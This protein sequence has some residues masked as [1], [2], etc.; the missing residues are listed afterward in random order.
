MCSHMVAHI[1]PYREQRALSFVIA[2]ATDMGLAE[3][4]DHD[5]TVHG[6]DDLAQ[7]EPVG[8]PGQDVTPAHTPFG[9]DEAS[10]L[11]REQDLLEV[12][13]RQPGALGNVT[14]RGWL[15][16]FV[17]RKGQQG[18]ARIIATRRYP[19]TTNLLRTR[20]TFVPLCAIVPIRRAFS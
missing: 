20:S 4:P 7:R 2:S 13:L 12:R 16:P 11:Q 6:G 3:I 10:A 17:Q 15:V 14:Y 19:H 8:R 9:P 1:C 18:T 5:R